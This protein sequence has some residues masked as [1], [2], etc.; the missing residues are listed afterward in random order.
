MLAIIWAPSV[1]PWKA[2]SSP[3][4]PFRPVNILAH[5]QA[6]GEQTANINAGHG[7]G[8]QPYHREDRV[9]AAH[10]EREFDEAEVALGSR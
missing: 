6:A 10:R 5:L 3:Y 7:N 9:A 8:E 2:F 4:I 1:F